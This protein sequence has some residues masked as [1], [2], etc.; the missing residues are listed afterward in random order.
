MYANKP[1]TDSNFMSSLKQIVLVE[2]TSAGRQ[3]L[4]NP[5]EFTNK[6]IFNGDYALA[7]CFFKVTRIGEGEVEQIDVSSP[8]GFQASQISFYNGT[9]SATQPECTGLGCGDHDFCWKT[10]TC[11][12]ETKVV[13]SESNTTV[14]SS[15]QS[16][17]DSNTTCT[18]FGCGNHDYCW[19]NGSCRNES[20]TTSPDMCYTQMKQEPC[21]GLEQCTW[22]KCDPSPAKAAG[23]C[24]PTTACHDALNGL[25]CQCDKMTCPIEE[26]TNDCFGCDGKSSGMC[27]YNSNF[28]T[29][30]PYG[31]MSREPDQNWWESYEQC[32]DKDSICKK[33][34]TMYSDS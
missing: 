14:P 11:G 10:N 33:V 32:P 31:N 30:E 19:K 20:D 22:L 16:Q 25:S 27:K 18:G 12:N 3:F 24:V 26:V 2:P 34:V 13:P 5:A 29:C 23:S 4:I 7:T 6:F 28:D 9:S 21:N 1:C 15:N 8:D 17:D